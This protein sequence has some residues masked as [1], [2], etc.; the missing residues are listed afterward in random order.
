MAGSACRAEEWQREKHLDHHRVGDINEKRPDH[1]HHQ[2]GNLRRTE[3]LSH[4]L[5]IGNRGWRGTQAETTV[6]SR[7]HAAS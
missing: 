3:A 2:E 6:P 5:H 1:R 4:R 7:Q